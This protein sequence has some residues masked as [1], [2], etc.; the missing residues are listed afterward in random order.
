MKSKQLTK[1]MEQVFLY[2]I[3]PVF[4]YLY[5]DELRDLTKGISLI[6]LF[7]PG[8]SVILFIVLKKKY[9]MTNKEIFY[10]GS[11]KKEWKSLLLMFTISVILY[12]WIT[13]YYMPEYFMKFPLENFPQWI[14]VMFLYPILSVIPQ[15]I[16]YRLFFFQR[17]Q[18]LYRNHIVLIVFSALYF[19]FAHIIF[20]NFI[21]IGFTI[22]GGLLFAWRYYRSRSILISCLEHSLYGNLLFTIGIGKFLVVE[23]Q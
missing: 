23:M 8:I 18:S 13:W 9:K 12:S 21:A 6:A 17:Y 5:I 7:L 15:G 11:W 16:I 22:M 4:I 14:L 19:C 1:W 20:N 10:I 2:L 3:I